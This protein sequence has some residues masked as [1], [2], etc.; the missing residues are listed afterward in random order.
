[1]HTFPYLSFFPY[2]FINISKNPFPKNIDQIALFFRELYHILEYISNSI[3]LFS[4]P[5]LLPL[6]KYTRYILLSLLLFLYQVFHLGNDILIYNV[7]LS[8]LCL[9]SLGIEIEACLVR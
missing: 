3:S 6:V 1:M 8:L 4:N 5:Q 9:S 2:L 7:D